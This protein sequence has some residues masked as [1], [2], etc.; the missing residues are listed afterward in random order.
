M[1]RSLD[2]DTDFFYVVV[3]ISQ[4]NIFASF[5]FIICQDYVL[6]TSIDLM[7]ENGFSQK[8]KNQTTSHRNYYGCRL[9]R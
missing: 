2:G 3:R 5:V 6:L 4:V 7:K 9:P 1:V 8:S